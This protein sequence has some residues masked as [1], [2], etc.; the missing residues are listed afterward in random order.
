ME[1]STSYEVWPF[2]LWGII[3]RQIPIEP[4]MDFKL[5]SVQHRPLIV[6]ADFIQLWEVNNV[7][8]GGGW[9]A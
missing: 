1:K 3:L 8:T 5:R 6:P 2:C 7:S 4:L 9:G